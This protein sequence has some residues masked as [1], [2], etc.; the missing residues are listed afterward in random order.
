MVTH[1]NFFKER[2]KLEFIP[3]NSE[4]ISRSKLH[5]FVNATNDNLHQY[6]RAYSK[7]MLEIWHMHELDRL[8]HFVM[9]LLTWAKRKL[10]ENWFASLSKAIMK[11]EGLSNVG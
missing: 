1:G 2:I 11:V 5:N 8:C 6:V 3:K 9:G 7:L 10:E 4:Y